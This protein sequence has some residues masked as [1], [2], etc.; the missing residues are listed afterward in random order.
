MNGQTPEEEDQ[1]QYLASTQTKDRTSLKEVKIR[2]VQTH[3]AMTLCTNKASSFPTKI[4]F[5]RSLVLSV[6]LEMGIQ[7]FVLNKCYRRML[8]T[9]S[10]KCRNTFGSRPVS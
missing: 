1:F 7:A 4:I 10:I 3:S 5:Y 9:E 8:G 2:L 6:D